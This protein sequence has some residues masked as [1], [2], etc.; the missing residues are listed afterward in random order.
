MAEEFTKEVDEALAA[1]TVLDTLPEELDGF[2][3]S[4]MRQEHEGQ[5]DFFR[6]D[7]PA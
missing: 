6:Y 5:Y 7:A 3:L 2:T 4:I 1:W